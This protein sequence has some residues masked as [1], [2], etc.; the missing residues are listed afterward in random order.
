VNWNL[1]GAIVALV[2]WVLV[3][4]VT[5]VG[6]GIVHLLLALGVGLVIRW[7]ALKYAA[8]PG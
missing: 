7:W 6:L 3:V 8:L 4:F 5:P 1:I 2:L